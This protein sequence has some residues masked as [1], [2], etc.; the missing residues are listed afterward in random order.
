MNT[1]KLQPLPIPPRIIPSF[2]NG[3]DAITKNFAL[4]LFPLVLD[5]IIWLGPKLQM[6][7]L[8]LAVVNDFE[9][10]K[11]YG[12]PETGE[13]IETSQQIW[14]QMADQLNLAI[15]LR[16]YPVGIP[17]LMVAESPLGIPFGRPLLF[18]VQSIWQ[19]FL[20][21]IV[22]GLMGVLFGAVY[23]TFVS[24]AAA[25]D[26]F[27]IGAAI[28]RIPKTA[29]RSVKL[30]GMLILLAIALSIPLSCIVSF[31]MMGGGSVGQ[32]GLFLLGGIVIWM[33]FP[34][35]F[36]AHGIFMN[37]IGVLGSIKQ[38]VKVTSMT[39]PSTGLFILSV[40]LIAQGMDIVWRFPD[41]TSW[42]TL[43]GIFGHAFIS[44]GLLA[45]SFFYYKDA[46][47]WVSEMQ[48]RKT[49]ETTE[50]EVQESDSNSR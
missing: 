23:F 34:L 9:R 40:M 26:G 22:L 4:I 12:T 15:S 17:S 32:L 24:Q 3:F 18:D 44:T 28:N 21:I 36:S 37:D 5:V 50:L 2:K 27:S 41:A 43:V 13:M 42:L 35:V 6:K 38:G 8:I 10:L 31:I 39:L 49:Q 14:T 7:S 19:A 16:T 45:A 47:V 48:S 20:V 33:L 11:A 46:V 25:N 30:F 29:F 1:T